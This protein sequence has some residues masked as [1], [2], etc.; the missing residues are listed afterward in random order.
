M[1]RELKELLKHETA[2]AQTDKIRRRLQRF[3]NTDNERAK[4]H[5]FIDTMQIALIELNAEIALRWFIRPN[6]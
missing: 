4:L 1:R 2:L 6:Q 5:K 3:K